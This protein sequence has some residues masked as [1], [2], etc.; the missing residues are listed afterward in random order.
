MTSEESRKVLAPLR[1]Q[2]DK[3]I[4]KKT[5]YVLIRYCQWVHVDDRERRVID[6][7]KHNLNAVNSTDCADIAI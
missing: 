5:N 1:R 2:K 4:P 3:A 6:D 7:K